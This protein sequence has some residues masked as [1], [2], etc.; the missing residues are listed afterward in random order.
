MLRVPFIPFGVLAVLVVAI[1]SG[2]A[3]AAGFVSISQTGPAVDAFWE[4]NNDDGTVTFVS[5][6]AGEQRVVQGRPP[7]VR[8]N[9]VFA[10]IATISF[11]DPEDPFDDSA[12]VITGFGD[13][14]PGALNIDT[15]TGSATL[16]LDLSAME[17]TFEP[18][19]PPSDCQQTMIS[20]DLA[21]AAVGE[22]F[23]PKDKFHDNL[24]N[25]R[26]RAHF[27][28]SLIPAE[29]SGT[30]SAG[31]EDHTRGEPTSFGTI[32]ESARD[33]VVFVAKNIE[34]CFGE[35]LPEP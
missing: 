10:D 25:C 4:F 14:P 19:A 24:E 16:D 2:R 23:K 9:Q 3:E 15:S 5:V 18:D 33:Q 22:S 29:A 6:F 13:L 34:D 11:G 35:P 1:S 31:G 12:H 17:C 20:I 28:G 7:P 8:L 27:K 26:I 21:W 32:V 30:I